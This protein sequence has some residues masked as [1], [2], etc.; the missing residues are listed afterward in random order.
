MGVGQVQRAIQDY[1]EA[2]RLDPKDPTAYHNLGL[3]YM[4]LEPER[5]IDTFGEALQLDP[6]YADPYFGRAITYTILGKDEEAQMNVDRAVGIGMDR[7]ALE[8]AI[9]ELKKL[10]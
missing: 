6:M 8:G 9:E 2:V 1:D 10:R 7:S 3:A 5:A 4:P